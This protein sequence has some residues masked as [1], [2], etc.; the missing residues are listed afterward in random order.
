MSAKTIG[1]TDLLDRSDRISKIDSEASEL[2][3]PLN[4][5]TSDV[6]DM[7]LAEILK[8]SPGG[9]IEAKQFSIPVKYSSLPEEIVYDRFYF[10]NGLNL[11][12]D[13]FSPPMTDAQKEE[14]AKDIA[15]KREYAKAEGYQYLAILGSATYEEIA[16][17]IAA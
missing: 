15:R 7:A 2:A 17:A 16:E 11:L 8:K 10:S 5:R 6:L 13:F 12:V 4:L 1:G 14:T 3:E 9:H